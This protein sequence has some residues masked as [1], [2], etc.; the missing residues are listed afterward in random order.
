MF[1][2]SILVLVAIGMVLLWSSGAFPGEADPPNDHSLTLADCI[3]IALDKNPSNRIAQEGVISA[4]ESVGEAR[5]PYY[6]ELGVQTAYKRWQS[7]A[8]LPSGL[9]IP[10]RTIP[11]IVGPTDDWMAGLNARYVL[12]DSGRRQ[13][14]YQSALARQGMAEE[15]KARI[16]Q[17]LI[18]SVHQGFY[19][20]AAAMETLSVAGENLNR[21]KDHVRLAKERKAAGAVS[22]ADVLRVQ[23]EASNAELDLVRAQ[24]LLRISKGTLNTIM[25]LPAE[26]VFE[27]A[28][29]LEEMASPDSIDLLKALD[30][31][32]HNRPEIK[33]ALKR[34]EAQ[35][36]NV[37]TARSAFGPRVRAEGSYGWRDSNFLPRDEEW[38]AGIT[39]EWPLFNGFSRKHR[40]A[41]AKAEVFKEEAEAKQL[42]LKVKQEVVTAHSRLKETYEAVQTTQTLIQD[43]QESLR[44]ARERYEVGA[45]TITDLLD[46]QTALARARATQV[47]A[48]WDFH[49]AQAVFRRS[50]G[51]ME[52]EPK[53][54]EVGKKEN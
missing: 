12:F 5:A 47:E 11:T 4:K 7:H 43:A 35:Q 39:I 21:A 28:P 27:V 19:G 42:L 29:K 3:R 25:G 40:L 13:A 24:S 41:K 54:Q 20:V 45:G 2:R 9:S 16:I 38:L 46:A 34:V 1:K 8:F 37:E 10:G 52:Q 30:Q 53:T 6:P 36:G 49:Q 14:E 51:L 26:R 48:E 23:V 18:L 22:R 15:E 50:L 17:D 32:V 44:M 33:G 31:A